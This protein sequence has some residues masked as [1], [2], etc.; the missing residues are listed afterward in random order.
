MFQDCCADFDHV[1]SLFEISAQDTKTNDDIGLWECVYSNL[2]RDIGVCMIS[3]CPSNWT[4]AVNKE[5]C[6]KRL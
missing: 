1:C 2:L 4:Q 5:H 3:S 6:S